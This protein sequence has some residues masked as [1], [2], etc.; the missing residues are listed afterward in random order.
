MQ[1]SFVGGSLFAWLFHDWTA[2]GLVFA[3]LLG[4]TSQRRPAAI[5]LPSNFAPLFFLHW[6]AVAICWVCS[7]LPAVCGTGIV[8]LFRQVDS[9]LLF[10]RGTGRYAASVAAVLYPLFGA[11]GFVVTG[12][13][14]V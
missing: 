13:Y 5:A 11:A 10:Q 2:I 3:V 14:P 1:R 6:T 9:D 4:L 8:A 12:F 7:C